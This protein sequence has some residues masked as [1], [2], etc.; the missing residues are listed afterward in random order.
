MSQFKILSEREHALQRSGMYIGSSTIEPITGFFCGEYQTLNV[1]PGLLKIVSEILDNSVDEF[2]RTDGKFANRIEVVIENTALEGTCVT[3][4]DNG[5]GIPVEKM[6]EGWKPTLA[7]TRARAGSNFDDDANRVTIGMNGV[8]S[9]LTNVFSTQFTGTTSDGKNKLVMRCENNGELKSENVSKSSQRFTEVSFY[10]DFSR[11]S[12]VSSFDADHLKYLQDRLENLVVCYPDLEFRLNGK[13]IQ[14]SPIKHLARKYSENSV[15]VD[16]E[17]SSLIVFSSGSD[18]DFRLLSYVNGLHIKNGGSHIEYYLRNIIEE[19]RELIKKKHKIE[20]A[21]AG[22]KQHL[23]VVSH[24]RGFKNPKFDSQTKERLTNTNAEVQEQLAGFDFRKIAKQIL[25]TEEI[26]NPIIEA[27]LFK[28]ELAERQALA[29]QQKKLQKTRIANHIQAQST[30][31]DETTLFITEGLS[32]VGQILSTRNP[33]TTGA[34][35]LKGKIMNTHGMKPVDIMKNK[36]LSE[37]V[38]ILGLEFGKKADPNYGKIA[39]MSDMDV[40]GSAIMCLLINFF[41]HWTNLF[42]EGKIYRCLTPLYIATK[43]KD[44]RFYY[45]KQEFTDAK[46]DSKWEVDYVKG[47]GSLPKAVYKEM[48]NNPRLVKIT[49]SKTSINSLEMAFG[50]NAD[51]RKNWLTG[52]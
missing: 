19:L 26:I 8:G 9:F 41:S 36:E 40:D 52:S 17:T 21:P 13:K 49:S 51:A 44:T 25:D 45:T 28:K 16:N 31:R 1:V 38:A 48:I 34:Y 24:I 20:V 47:L 15:C 50:D 7:W 18:A 12:G 3:I 35:P 27:I 37:L 32:A 4:K 30:N 43:G 10:P 23:S 14:S 11:F 2:V 22:I 46:L 29:R 5:R 6:N 33:K 39:I 42:E